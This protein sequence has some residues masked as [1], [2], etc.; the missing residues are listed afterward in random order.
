MVK[1]GLLWLA[2]LPGLAGAAPAA[3]CPLVLQKE[4]VDVRAPAGW[5]G[6]SSGIMRLTGYGMMAG[7]PDSMA[8]LVPANSKTLKRGAPAIW[9]FAAGDEKWLYCTYDRSAAVQISR[10]MDDAATVCELSHK[11]DE[12]GA[13]ARWRRCAGRNDAD[14]RRNG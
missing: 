13:L 10:R 11:K 2:V 8:Y 4:A 1:A 6:Y 3:S 12:H 7:P 5:K 14:G 9:R